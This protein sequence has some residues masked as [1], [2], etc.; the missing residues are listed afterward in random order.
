MCF[1]PTISLTVAITEFILAT[2]LLLAFPK[3]TLRNFSAVLIYILGFYQFTEFMLCTSGSPFF[4]ARLGFMTYTLLP[5]VGLNIALK[6]TNR[7]PNYLHYF[8]I[9]IIPAIFWI[10]AL[11][12]RMITSASCQTFFVEVQSLFN[13]AGAIPNNLLFMIYTLYYLS[14]IVVSCLLFYLHFRKEK[15]KIKKQIDLAYIF[16]VFLMTVP[17]M[18]FLVIFPFLNTRFPSVLCGFAIFVAI[19]SFIAVYL[20]SKLNKKTKK[21]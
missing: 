1:T 19:T 3:T 17:T 10:L 4:W 15:N 2:I 9:Y 12:F 20:E 16:G 5:A 8:L 14:F 18:V 11:S 13:Q 7:K 21:R 6:F